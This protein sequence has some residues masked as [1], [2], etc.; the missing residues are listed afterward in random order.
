MYSQRLGSLGLLYYS[1][2]EIKKEGK[3]IS[4]A[5]NFLFA[6]PEPDF[7]NLSLIW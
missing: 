1:H 3:I 2:P 6:L 7:V 5:Q 4:G